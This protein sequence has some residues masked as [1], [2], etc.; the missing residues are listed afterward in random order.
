M[1]PARAAGS[2]MRP[3]P[4]PSSSTGPTA[5][6]RE[7]VAALQAAGRPAHYA[8][9]DSPWGHDAFLIEYD[10]LSRIVREEADTERGISLRGDPP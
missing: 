5:L 2:R 10:Q 9:I 1:H 3:V 6:Q 8:E 4:Q 7:I